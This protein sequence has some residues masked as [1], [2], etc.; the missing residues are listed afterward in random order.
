MLPC[1]CVMRASIEDGV[2]TITYIPCKLS[3]ENYRNTL[4]LAEGAGL[5]VTTKMGT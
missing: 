2:R 4:T 3:C 1:G 5:P